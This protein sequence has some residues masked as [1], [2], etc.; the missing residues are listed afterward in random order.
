MIQIEF[1]QKDVDVLESERY[2]Y[3][4]PKVQRKMEV[5][6][7][8][9]FGMAHQQI[10]NICRISEPTLLRYL[11]T[12]QRDGV[13]ALKCHRYKGKMNQLK[14]HAESLEA[15]FQEFPPHT[16]AQAQ[17]VIEQMTGVRRGLTQVRM[18]LRGMKMKYRKCG[19]VPGKAD[20]PEKMVE[21]EEYLKKTSKPSCQKPKQDSGWSFS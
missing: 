3:P 13:S 18:F 21:Q 15:H 11:Q 2:T 6:Y 9:S 19:F 12:Y 14:P 1:T 10:R 7:L 8:K 5:L 4:D 16:C 20:T 17:E